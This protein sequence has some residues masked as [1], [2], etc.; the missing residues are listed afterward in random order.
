MFQI[1]VEI[2]AI[3]VGKAKIDSFESFEDNVANCKGENS[4]NKKRKIKRDK[5]K[6]GESGGMHYSKNNIIF[7][8]REE[9]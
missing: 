1:F 7:Q 2:N 6:L 3:S 8:Y 4:Q 9:E 5:E